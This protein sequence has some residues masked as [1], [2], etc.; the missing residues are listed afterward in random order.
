MA[1]PWV[2]IPIADVCASIVDCVN[3]TAPVVDEVTPY[4]MIR[5]TNV[6]DGFVDVMEV[7]HVTEETYRIWTRRQVPEKFDVI[8]TREAPLG[9]VGILRRP[10]GIFLGQRLITYRADPAKV[11]PHF[12]LYS[13]MEDY[14]RGQV[15]SF[16][17]GATV[18]H[19]RV[20]DASRLMI[21]VPPLLVQQQIGA[22][23]GAMDELIENNVRRIQVVEEV[24]R[25]SFEEWFLQ[26]SAS[27]ESLSPRALLQEV[28]VTYGCPFRSERFNTRGEGVALVRIRDVADGETAT[29]TDEEADARY[30]IEDGDVLVGM[31]GDFHIGV[32]WSG[33]AY[34]NQRVAR[35]RATEDLPPLL[36]KELLRRPIERFNRSIVGTTVAHLGDK[37]L[38]EIVVDVPQ[39]A[40]LVRCRELFGSL[41]AKYISLRK[42]NATLRHLRDLLLPKVL[43]GEVDVSRLPLPPEAP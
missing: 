13:F 32:W 9:E 29:W 30:L 2:E 5:T 37:H 1:H 4:K 31:D 27:I 7:R 15:M 28:P 16:G 41:S 26:R 10:E 22:F 11:D 8:L 25:R 19:M 18:Q 20:P 40:L 3:K 33:R 34:L 12:L 24:A 38:R 6:R 14:L 17:S 35:F 36:L 23:L 21:R 39:G 42:R 43:S